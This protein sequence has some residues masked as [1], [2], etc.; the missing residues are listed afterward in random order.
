MYAYVNVYVC[1]L[2]TNTFTYTC[3]YTQVV[4]LTPENRYVHADAATFVAISAFIRRV[5]VCT[6]M[7]LWHVNV[8]L[9]VVYQ[10]CAD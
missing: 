1:I 6:S 2:H 4:A 9:C 10:E 7:C 3:A 8:Y 5:Q